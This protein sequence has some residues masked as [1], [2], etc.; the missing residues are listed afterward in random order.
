MKKSPLKK[1]QEI[2]VV[3]PINRL[4]EK[5]RPGEN[6]DV[7]IT[8]DKIKEL[9]NSLDNCQELQEQEQDLLIQNIFSLWGKIK[10]S[11]EEGEHCLTMF[12]IYINRLDDLS[13]T[14]CSEVIQSFIRL[15]KRFLQKSDIKLRK[16]RVIIQAHLDVINLAHM[17]K[18][19]LK[20]T[21]DAKNLYEILE[22]AIQQNVD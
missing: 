7:Y 20:D 15:L 3:H 10:S 12:H 6:I 22:I 8:E 4:K 11:P 21:K 18:I 13:A 5:I 16:H 19:H 9:Q 17:Q 14:F 1:I 2:I